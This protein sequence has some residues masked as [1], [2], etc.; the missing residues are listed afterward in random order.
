ME[1]LKQHGEMLDQAATDYQQDLAEEQMRQQSD[2]SETICDD[3]AEL[4]RDQPT[5][6]EF[7]ALSEMQAQT[8]K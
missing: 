2:D 3:V 8:M 7:D 6:S 1:Q 5:K 4:K